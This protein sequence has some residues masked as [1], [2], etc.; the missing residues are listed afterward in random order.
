MPDTNS[1]STKIKKIK[2]DNT[3]Y[4]VWD[5]NAVHPSDALS[6]TEIQSIWDT[7]KISAT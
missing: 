5:S 3:S 1:T 7:G 6:E 4:D 2:V